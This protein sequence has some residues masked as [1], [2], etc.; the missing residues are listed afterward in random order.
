[1]K[2]FDFWQD[3]Q[4]QNPKVQ[5]KHTF[6]RTIHTRD[7]QLLCCIFLKKIPENQIFRKNKIKPAAIV[8][9]EI[10]R[11]LYSF[12]HYDVTNIFGIFCQFQFIRG[13]FW[14][15]LRCLEQINQGYI[16]VSAK[17]K[18]NRLKK[19]G[20]QEKHI[21]QIQFMQVGLHSLN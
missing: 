5:V 10:I 13:D 19:T 16:K 12:C 18:L 14:I 11:M 7:S 4:R 2:N 15:S 3:G 8:N 17:E 9:H 21:S 1:M 20:S 6:C